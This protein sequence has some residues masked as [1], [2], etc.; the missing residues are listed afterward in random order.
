MST[1]IAGTTRM[2]SN[3]IKR[4]SGL[5][6]GLRTM[7]ERC[8]PRIIWSEWRGAKAGFRKV[9]GR[10]HICFTGDAAEFMDVVRGDS[11]AE[12]IMQRVD[13]KTMYEE[14]NRWKR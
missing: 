6:R 11:G 3:R 7:R 2:P 9:C 8:S 10:G 4:R 14:S 5:P 13:F 1:F 12:S